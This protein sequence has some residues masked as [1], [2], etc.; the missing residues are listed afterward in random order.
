MKLTIEKVFENPT[1]LL[2]RASYTFQHHT[3]NGEMSFIL[4]FS[5]SG[6]PRFHIYAKIKDG[7]LEINL[8]LDQK[9]HTYG[10]ETRHH[11]EYEESPILEKEAERLR[12][13]LS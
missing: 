9:K 2:R 11:G 13:F 4:P 7:N 8:H 1:T 12:K 5:Q 10:N 6:F 3:E